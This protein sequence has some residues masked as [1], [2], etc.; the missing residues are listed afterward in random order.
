M[1]K[2]YIWSTLSENFFGYFGLFFGEIGHFQP[3]IKIN[4]SQICN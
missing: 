2:F 3:Q 4:S 1:T